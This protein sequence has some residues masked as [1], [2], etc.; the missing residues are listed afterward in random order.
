MADYLELR[1]QRIRLLLSKNLVAVGV[2]GCH[3]VDT[4]DCIINID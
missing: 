4:A 2:N 1:L 3:A